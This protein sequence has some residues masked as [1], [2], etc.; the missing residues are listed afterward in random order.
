MNQKTIA[1]L[2][3]TILG[4][5]GSTP[6]TQI[7]AFGD[8]TKAITDKVEGV[9]TEYN[10]SAVTRSMT[11]YASTYTGSYANLLTSDLLSAIQP[12]I[13]PKAKHGFAL[14]KANDAIGTYAQALSDLASA[15]SRADIDLASAKLYG[16]IVGVNNQYKAINAGAQD[17]FG[18]ED[19]AGITQLFAAIGSTLVEEKRADAIKGIV[20]AADPKI[21]LL[22]D[23]IDKQLDDSGISQGISTSRQY[24]LT[25]ELKAY[26]AQAEKIT[27]LEWR[28]SEIK[29]LYELQ[30]SVNNS[31]LLVQ[32]AQKAIRTVKSTHATLATEVKNGKINSE[33]IALAVGRLKD[34]EKHYDSY[35]QLLLDCKKIEQDA[36]G[37]L[38]CADKAN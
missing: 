13:D 32:T 12:P 19:Y 20:L 6:T 25:E 36:Q 8:S 1:I 2:L 33:S 22:C 31:K 18:M 37:I 4:G 3:M 26:K 5:C 34:L 9:L 23:T 35:E 16:A 11:D 21:A 10:D 15:G 24:V 7:K 17:L 14:Y 29:R 27:T 28:R 30:R 38:Q